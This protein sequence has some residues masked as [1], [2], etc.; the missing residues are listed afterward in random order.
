M[1][2]HEG[3]YSQKA[4]AIGGFWWDGRLAISLQKADVSSAVEQVSTFFARFALKD[5][6]ASAGAVSS[7]RLAEDLRRTGSGKL[8]VSTATHPTVTGESGMAGEVGPMNQD[9]PGRGSSFFAPVS[10]RITT[11]TRTSWE[12]KTGGPAQVPDGQAR[13]GDNR[14]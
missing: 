11:I 5:E 1:C 4:R 13:T 12:G 8:R 9:S 6:V 14:S 7:Q 10:A 2:L 3:D